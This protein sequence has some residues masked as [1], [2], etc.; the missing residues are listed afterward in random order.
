MDNLSQKV[1]VINQMVV[2]NRCL[3]GASLGLLVLVIYLFMYKEETP[4]VIRYMNNDIE[5]IENYKANS[6]VSSHDIDIFIRHFVHNWSVTD[7]FRFESDLPRALNMMTPDLS[8]FYLNQKLTDD[9]LVTL[10]N[11]NYRT[12]IEIFGRPEYDPD[13]LI[14][15]V[16][17]KRKMINMDD[18]PVAFAVVRGDFAIK[19][20]EKRTK[21]NPYGL[22]LYKYTETPLNQ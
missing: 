5:V 2:V 8:R 13:Q 1:G 20:L 12:E 21:D 16:T 6:S 18:K 19:K 9:F 11:A 3:M 15:S 4:I 17:F 10:K 22:L 7:S 14:G